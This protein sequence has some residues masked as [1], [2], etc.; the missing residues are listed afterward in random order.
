MDELML[1]TDGS[2]DTRSR[3]GCGA[4]LAIIERGLSLDSLRSQVQVRRFENTSSTKLELQTLLW[5]LRSVQTSGKRVLIYSDSQNILSLP[6][7]RDGLEQNDYRSKKNR[8]LNNYE[9]YQ[10]FF[11]IIDRLDCEFIKVR[12]HK[13][14]HQKDEIDALFTLVDR[15]SRNA[16][17]GAR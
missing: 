7:R 3:I 5:A 15:A 2:V 4:Y 13:A 14:S 17:R 8:H 16:L 6:E 12:G 1:F 10:E 11:G 9:L